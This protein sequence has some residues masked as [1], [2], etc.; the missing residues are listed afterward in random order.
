M[1][2]QK[3]HKMDA[4]GKVLSIVHFYLTIRRHFTLDFKGAG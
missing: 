1:D 2:A 4:H 3:L